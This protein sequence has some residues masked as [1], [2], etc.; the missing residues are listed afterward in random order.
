MAAI[1]GLGPLKVERYGEQLLRFVAA[2]S[3]P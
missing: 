1:P 2:G 3:G